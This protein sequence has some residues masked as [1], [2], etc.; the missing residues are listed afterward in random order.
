M[1][2]T[3]SSAPHGRVRACGR[4]SSTRPVLRS[5]FGPRA[6]R[7]ATIASCSKPVRSSV[8]PLGW[9]GLYVTRFS[10]SSTAPG[11]PGTSPSSLS[12]STHLLLHGDQDG[13]GV[14][15]PALPRPRFVRSPLPFVIPPRT[16]TTSTIF[17]MTVTYLSSLS[18]LV[19]RSTAWLSFPLCL[20]ALL[21][22]SRWSGV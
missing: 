6:P 16:F 14:H 8:P 4:C 9:P 20:H 11:L 18:S 19:H 12:T 3:I 15:A 5:S 2:V 21:R 13:C 1:L 22:L 7:R 10:F 17:A